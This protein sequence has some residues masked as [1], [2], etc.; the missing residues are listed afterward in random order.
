MRLLVT[1]AR[2][3]LGADVVAAADRAGHTVSGAGR[4]RCDI[5][6]PGAAEFAIADFQPDVVINCAAWTNV[7]GAEAD[8]D[9]VYR[10][11][12]IGPR[13]LAAAC[14]SAGVRLSHVSTDYVFDGSATAPIH[15][16]AIPGPLGVY[17]AS[18]LAGEHEVRHHCPAHQIVRTGWLFGGDGPNFVRTM[19]R[20]ARERGALRVVAD[21]T[22]GPTWTG[23]LA[24]ALV[25]LAELGAPGTYHL[26][27]QGV[28]TWHGFASAIMQE[29]GMPSIP[30]QPLSTDQYPTPAPRPAYT[31][32]DNRAWR[33]LG[34]DALPDWRH[35]LRGYLAQHGSL[36]AGDRA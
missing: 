22:G 30:V 35:G 15:E 25:R 5:A 28:T 10:A 14:H 32:L 3:Q 33:L 20:L 23:H 8:V 11:N 4:A 34:M 31:V 7:D 1:G 2:G 26:T 13:L 18:K 16:W 29:S 24:P 17:G 27:G 12:A 21:Q 9:A 6:A 36:N 19:L